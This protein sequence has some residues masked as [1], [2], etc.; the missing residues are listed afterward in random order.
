MDCI[1]SIPWLPRR[2]GH[3]IETC[4]TA[5]ER[6]CCFAVDQ[7]IGTMMRMVKPIQFKLG[8]VFFLTAVVALGLRLLVFDD[9]PQGTGFLVGSAFVLWVM[10]FAEVFRRWTR[11]R[12][13]KSSKICAG[14][15]LSGKIECTD[16]GPAFSSTTR[17]PLAP[18]WLI[19]MLPVVWVATA[20]STRLSSGWPL[21]VGAVLVIATAWRMK[22]LNW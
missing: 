14:G 21:V 9:L 4:E 6:L 18:R 5:P 2:L 1:R 7:A 17:K 20:L 15:W 8:S 19:L 3:G 12:S 22:P 16:D 13:G 11:D 10:V